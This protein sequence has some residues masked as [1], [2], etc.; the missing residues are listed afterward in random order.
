VHGAAQ[1]RSN[2]SMACILT[3]LFLLPGPK[4]QNQVPE[5]IQ[6]LKD[7]K[8]DK[9]IALLKEIGKHKKNDTEAVDLVKL[10][11]AP[12]PKRPPEVNEAI[13]LALRDIGSRKV[14]SK[15]IALF[16]HTRLKKD[17][18]ARKG[19][20]LA[21]GGAADPKAVDELCDRMRD[22]DDHVIAAAIEAAGFYRYSK[23]SIRKEL[24][25]S[26]LGVYV[27][28]WNMKESIKPEHK[29]QRQRAE[30]KWEVIAKPS[31]KTLRLLS[32]TTQEDPP[33][34]RRWWN[35]VKKKKWAEIEN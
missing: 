11:K 5:V 33:A 29:T 22:P 27:P 3:L 23:E 12:R 7:E 21:L 6:L 13:F 9:A 24:F 18:M 8:P 10:V 25:K 32:N 31:E 1:R 2:G 14:T 4:A 35:K 19:I 30:R 17:P 20:C 28:T 15:L 34:W 26:A 16:K